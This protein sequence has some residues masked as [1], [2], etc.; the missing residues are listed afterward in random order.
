MISAPALASQSKASG[1]GDA[2]SDSARSAPSRVP[3]QSTEPVVK[4]ERAELRAVEVHRDPH[5]RPLVAADDGLAEG[6]GHRIHQGAP[7]SRNE[8][9]VRRRAASGLPFSVHERERMRM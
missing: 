3:S 2:V 6:V 9:A 5:D 7:T 8:N 4:R 1:S